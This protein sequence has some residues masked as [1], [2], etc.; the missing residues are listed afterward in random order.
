MIQKCLILLILF[1]LGWI[2]V[3][4]QNLDIELLQKINIENPEDD[5]F[6]MGVTNSIQWVPAAYVGGNLSYGLIA[7]DKDALRYSLES[8]MGMGISIAI[9]G[10]L[11]HLVK[12]PRPTATYP[13]LIQ[14]YA[15]PSNLSFPSSHSA[16]TFSLATTASY[17]TGGKWYFVTPVF[18]Y[19]IGVGYSRMRLGRHYPSDVLV[20]MLIGVASGIL[21]HW[22]TGQIV[23]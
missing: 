14:S 10:G 11:K 19:P 18:T 17:Q 8:T 22:V 21:G 9:S 6:W 15:Q 23:R 1:G 2:Q 4:A 12:R 13:D 5:K 3:Q 7:N 16:L 20:G